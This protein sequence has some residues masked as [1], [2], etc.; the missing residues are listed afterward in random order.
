VL[1]AISRLSVLLKSLFLQDG[2]EKHLNALSRVASSAL[3]LLVF[4]KE[5]QAAVE[6]SLAAGVKSKK[7]T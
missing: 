5:P 2:L 1:K 6:M 7:T 4:T 3:S